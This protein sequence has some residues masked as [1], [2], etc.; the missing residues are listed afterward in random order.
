M[1]LIPSLYCALNCDTSSNGMAEREVQTFKLALK[2]ATKTNVLVELDRFLFQYRITLHS[3]NNWS[4]T[5]PVPDGTHTICL[6][7]PD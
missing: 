1:K 2:K 3:Y 5:C 4:C 7:G 6:C